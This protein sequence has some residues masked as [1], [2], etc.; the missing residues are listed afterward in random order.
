MESRLWRAR[1]TTRA[2][3]GG[4]N[5][6][7]CKHTA[8]TCKNKAIA[9]RRAARLLLVSDRGRRMALLRAGATCAIM[10]GT[11][12]AS[13]DDTQNGDK[14][15]SDDKSGSGDDAKRTRQ[16]GACN[17]VQYSAGCGGTACDGA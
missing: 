16:V 3:S 17:A 7:L 14:S 1:H 9:Q 12:T 8:H 11:H 2:E 10:A 6:T 13:A 5:T 15:G 4:S